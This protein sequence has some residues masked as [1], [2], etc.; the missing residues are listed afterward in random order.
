MK[1]IL[2]IIPVAL[3]V[4]CCGRHTTAKENLDGEVEE[5]AD[6][7]RLEIEFPT[8]PAMLETDEDKIKYIAEH[9]WDKFD[10]ADTAYIDKEDVTEQAFADY[11]YLLIN[12]DRNVV[13]IS[14]GR[15][16][17]AAEA[18]PL[19]YKYFVGLFEKYLY[20]EGSPMRNEEVY[21]VVLEHLVKSDVL[22]EYEKIR[23]QAQLEMALKNRVGDKANDVVA[24]LANGS[25]VRL[26]NIK[27]D[28][29]VVFIYNP[30]CN[31]CAEV[32]SE[33]E[34]SKNVIQRL[35]DSGVLKILAVYPDED[36][37]AWKEHLGKMPSKWIVGY[38]AG[39]AM[40]KNKTYDLRAIPTL[41]LLDKD[42]KVLIKDFTDLRELEY[43]FISVGLA[44]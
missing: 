25:K 14:V 28:Y 42:K 19:M 39:Q 37:T 44:N 22:D 17:K 33:Y 3:L 31:A 43:Y 8:P 36:L 21:I 7:T 34:M 41:Y 13:E 2:Y 40:T 15:M 4:L 12:L 23:P 26:Y 35:V 24:T 1:K 29:T 9:Y 16:L 18:E 32:M 27:A 6:V 11:V 38:D 10:F 5:Q 20:E 30:D